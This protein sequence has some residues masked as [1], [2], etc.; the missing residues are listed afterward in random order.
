MLFEN[1]ISWSLP[2]KETYPQALFAAKRKYDI[3]TGIDIYVPLHTKVFPIESGKVINIEWFTGKFSKPPTEWWNDT[4]A[5]WVQSQNGMVFVYGEIETTIKIGDFVSTN[6]C[7]GTVLQV[8][9]KEKN[10]N[11]LTML[12]IE[13]YSNIPKETV[14]WNHGENQPEG[15]LNP[16]DYI[17]EL[18]CSCASL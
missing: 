11:P 14:I 4:K 12:H 9:K 16:L 8:L 6:T 1:H 7:I 13:L 15:L 5:V 2:T 17:E 10:K 3:H 18:K